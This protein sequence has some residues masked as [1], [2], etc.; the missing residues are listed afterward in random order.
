M[1]RRIWSLVCCL[2]IALVLSL[3]VAVPAWS[4][5]KVL[6][7][8]MNADPRTIDPARTTEV[9]A[10]LVIMN[11]F[12]GLMGFGTDG[13]LVPVAAESYEVSPDGLVYT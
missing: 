2:C 7:L 9:A 1:S 8:N 5:E 11:C 10:A 3:G 4:A 13:K 6:K 12:E